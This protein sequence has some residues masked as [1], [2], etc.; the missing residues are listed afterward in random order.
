[1]KR[2]NIVDPRDQ[3]NPIDVLLSTISFLDKTNVSSGT[4][5]L[6][7]GLQNPDRVEFYEEWLNSS[8]TDTPSESG[9]VAFHEVLHVLFGGH[10]DVVDKLAIAHPEYPTIPPKKGSFITDEQWKRMNQ[11]KDGSDDIAFGAME[12]WIDND[13]KN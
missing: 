10:R 8:Y 6:A 12:T 3:D 7:R 5:A 13:C 1:M 4:D 2:L 11:M 9:H